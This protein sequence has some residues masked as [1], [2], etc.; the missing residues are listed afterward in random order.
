M[1]SL[2]IAQ[3]D[4]RSSE[5]LLGAARTENGQGNAAAPRA[6]PELLVRPFK[7]DLDLQLAEVTLGLRREYGHPKLPVRVSV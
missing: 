1:R 5:F 7:V 3:L 2:W 6:K 4:P